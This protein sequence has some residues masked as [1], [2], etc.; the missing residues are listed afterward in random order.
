MITLSSLSQHLFFISVVVLLT[1]AL[2][3]AAAAVASMDGE[4]YLAEWP[5]EGPS[6]RL[7]PKNQKSGEVIREEF[8]GLD[9]LG[10]QEKV[11]CYCCRETTLGFHVVSCDE[12]TAEGL[13]PFVDFRNVTWKL[14]VHEPGKNLSWTTSDFWG[15]AVLRYTFE[16]LSEDRTVHMSN[17]NTTRT[18]NFKK[19]GAKFTIS[20]D[21]YSPLLFNITEEPDRYFGIT[22]LSRFFLSRPVTNTSELGVFNLDGVPSAYQIPLAIRTKDEPIL[23]ASFAQTI[24]SLQDPPSG[25]RETLHPS[26]W[27]FEN[28]DAL[29][30]DL[31][32]VNGEIHGQYIELLFAG[33]HSVFY[34]PDLSI[35]LETSEEDGGKDEEEED[36]AFPIAFS[37]TVAFVIVF[38]AVSGALFW[39]HHQNKKDRRLS[40]A[41]EASVNF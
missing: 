10:F 8:F 9:V 27:G 1:A 4:S 34:D 7:F 21:N 20:F 5:E 25:S 17:G 40:V 11:L 41:S 16:D 28:I 13:G 33:A 3:G 24:F 29:Q 32:Y 14:E 38:M 30:R 12:N 39:R 37:I 36:L 22:T 35:L 23:E 18:L 26:E 6:L 31:Y 15:E 2:S 19:G